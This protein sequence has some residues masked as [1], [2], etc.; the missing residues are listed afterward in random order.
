MEY[1]LRKNLFNS[2]DVFGIKYKQDIKYSVSSVNKDG[3]KELYISNVEKEK[4]VQITSVKS[5]TGIEFKISLYGRMV[6]KA[7]CE[8]KADK[9]ITFRSMY[10][11]EY[12]VSNHKGS[13]GLNCYII[14]K[15]RLRVAKAFRKPL[16][17]INEY[18]IDIIEAENQALILAISIVID[19]Y[20]NIENI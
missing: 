1:L 11:D 7:V 4:I 18:S 14:R 13:I 3:K 10:G 6:L 5:V 16:S 9:E 2:K 15:N 20:F 12:E 19:E 17:N 8:D